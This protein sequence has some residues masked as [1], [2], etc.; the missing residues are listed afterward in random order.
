MYGYLSVDPLKH[1]QRKYQIPSFLV[2]LVDCGLERR[3]IFIFF[4]K[5]SVIYQKIVK[6]SNN[7][8]IFYYLELLIR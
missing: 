7:F 5:F 1:S 3:I 6:K 2:N 8:S 4:I